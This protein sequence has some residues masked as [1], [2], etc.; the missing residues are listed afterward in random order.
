MNDET[1]RRTKVRTLWF[2]LDGTRRI[3][4]LV[5]CL[6]VPLTMGLDSCKSETFFKSN[7]DSTPVNQPPSSTQAVGTATISGLPGS[8]L[9]A[10]APPDAAPPAKWLRIFRLN[11][12]SQIAVFRGQLKQQ[13]GNG[14]YV[15]STAL[16][17]PAGNTG[18]ASI[19]FGTPGPLSSESE[20]LHLDFMPNGRVR[21]DDDAST[22]FG[23]FTHNQAFLVQVTLNITD[24]SAK[25]RI[26]LSGAG[27]S[28]QA[29]RTVIPAF[30]FRAKQFGSVTLFM[31]F[32]HVGTF[33]A[34]NVVVTRKS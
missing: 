17:I 27:A 20:F 8:V 14:L 1:L 13:A 19:S 32:P 12:P 30:L 6:L 3:G 2:G 4:L 23:S 9:V 33:H 11:D 31:G 25:A 28:G 5:L 10:P 16:V 7:F 21:I 15:F 26:V 34:A 18:P 24:T 22:L 29:D